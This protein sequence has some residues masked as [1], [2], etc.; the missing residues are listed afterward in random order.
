[1]KY[2]LFGAN[3]FVGA[4]LKK[5][6]G[7]DVKLIDN[8]FLNK[9]FELDI[10]KLC[11]VD[12]IDKIKEQ[13]KL[14]S[15]PFTVINLAAIH[16]IPYCENNPSE[17]FKSNVLGNLLLAEAVIGTT[18][19]RFMLASSGAVYQPSEGIHSEKDTLCSSDIYSASKLSAENDIKAI[20]SNSDID[21][22]ILRFFNI[23][24]KGDFTPHI[25]PDLYEQVVSESQYINHGNLTTVRDYIHVEDACDAI[26]LLSNSAKR[27]SVEAYNVCTGIGTNGY[28]LLNELV[29]LKQ[30][31]K[32][33]Y[34][35]PEKV[36]KSDRP[37]QI[38][39][40]QKLHN[41]CGWKPKRSFLQ[42]L[43]DYV[44]FRDAM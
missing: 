5:H 2:F 11:I 35:D 32:E 42:G 24:G 3:G 12:N 1:M 38:G 43:Q 39:N 20:F 21:V 10:E 15:S 25:I 31:T 37:A 23:I 34:L 28:A 27:Y 36:R 16:H 22:D 13:F 26:M 40:Y 29:K 19:K 14:E 17:T 8:G 30:S 33:L 4:N 41:Y 7:K 44:G 6:L 18:C 9:K